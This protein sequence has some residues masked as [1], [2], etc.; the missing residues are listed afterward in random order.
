[1]KKQFTDEAIILRTHNVGETDRFCILLTRGHGKIAARAHGV[2]RLVS[3]RGGG[4][5]PMH[6]SSIT[7]EEHS[8]GVVVTAATCLDAHRSAWNDPQAFGAAARGVELVLVLTEEGVDLRDVYDLTASF[9]SS[10]R[11]AHSALLVP[12]FTCKLLRILGLFPSV[13]H[14]ALGDSLLA[15]EAFVFHPERGGFAHR[16]MTHGV[17]V[18]PGT[19]E[20]LRCLDALAFSS[21]P[22]MPPSTVFE[23]EQITQGLLGSQLGASLSSPSVSRSLSSAVTPICQ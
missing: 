3:K 7:L 17:S 19:L 5:L 14:S 6:R 15:S 18:S 1:M 2:R 4:L 8:F 12:V 11:E 21:L 23:L 16:G 22:A 13:T 10:C 9:L 20:L